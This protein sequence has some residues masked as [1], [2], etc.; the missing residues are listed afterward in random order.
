MSRPRT[1]LKV[2]EARGSVA[3]NPQ[4]YRERMARAATASKSRL[5]APPDKWNVAPEAIGAI[6]Y[7]RWKAIW[8]EFADLVPNAS[9]LKRVTLELLCEAMDRFRLNPTSMKTS[10]RAL[11]VTLIKQLES[12]EVSVSGG[13]KPEGYGGQWEAFG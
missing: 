11:I 5:G 1:S 12:D 8:S 7:A 2:L 3:K 9:P 4:R 6:K 10:D 13:K